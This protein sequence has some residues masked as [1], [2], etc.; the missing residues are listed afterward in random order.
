MRDI[1]RIFLLVINIISFILVAIFGLT[2]IVYEILGPASYERILAKL[3]FPWSFG[4]IW[5]F[6]FICLAVSIITYF[7]RKKFFG[8]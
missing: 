8:A 4:Q 3:K 5:T 1:V 6:C 7:L 2:G